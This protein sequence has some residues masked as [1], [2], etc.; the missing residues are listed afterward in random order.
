MPFPSVTVVRVRPV[1]VCATVT[2]TPGS[3]A[4]D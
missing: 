2:V 3:T 4:P 1:A